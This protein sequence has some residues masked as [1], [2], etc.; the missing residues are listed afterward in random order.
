M[1]A[2]EHYS[3]RQVYPASATSGLFLMPEREDRR[4]ACVC[5]NSGYGHQRYT[6]STARM[7]S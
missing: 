4:L 2:D 1:S 6:S 3:V 5:F 7:P